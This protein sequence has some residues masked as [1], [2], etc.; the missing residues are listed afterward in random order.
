MTHPLVTQRGLFPDPEQCFYFINFKDCSTALFEIKLIS[1]TT[2]HYNT[3]DPI[4]SYFAKMG[5]NNE[6]ERFNISD[7]GFQRVDNK[8]MTVV[9][10]KDPYLIIGLA[11][12]PTDIQ[13]YTSFSQQWSSNDDDLLKRKR[14]NQLKQKN[15][16]IDTEF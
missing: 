11:R 8:S 13:C 10:K 15:T 12:C 16:D 4:K 7:C 2:W 5:I 6:N 1:P 9:S 3:E 14:E